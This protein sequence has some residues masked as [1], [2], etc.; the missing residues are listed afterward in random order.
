MDGCGFPRQM[1][2]EARHFNGDVVHLHWDSGLSIDSYRYFIKK[3]QGQGIKVHALLG[4]PHW[5]L[6]EYKN[7]CI[8]KIKEITAYN[9]QVSPNERFLGIQLDSEP[10]LLRYPLDWNNV[11]DREE[12][13]KQWLRTS[14]EYISTI[15]K[16]NLESGAA[17]PFWFDTSQEVEEAISLDIANLSDYYKRI[18]DLYNYIVVMAYRDTA[19]DII[20]ISTNEI[21]Y[22]SHPK[23]VI[24]I[25]TTEQI[26]TYVTFYE[27]GFHAAEEDISIIHAQKKACKSFKGIAIH[28]YSQWEKFLSG[29]LFGF[30]SS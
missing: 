3:A 5:A 13:L 17:I 18:I 10:Y 19:D 7:S 30:N 14:R 27:K 8:S 28:N 15:N 25:E 12:V 1:K 11:T 4:D 16:Y 20:D 24:G 22:L 2:R 21:D 6:V 9:D 26:P 29:F 23:I